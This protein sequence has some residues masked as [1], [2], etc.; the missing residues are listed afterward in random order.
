MEF[1][2]GYAVVSPPFLGR[3]LPPLA[4]GIAAHYIER[5][6]QR[7]DL[8][9]DPFGQGAQVA[10]EALRLERR[11]LVACANP[12]SRLALSLAVRPPAEGE[13]RSALTRLA[14]APKDNSRLETY[15]K[16][17]YRTACA[18]CGAEVSADGF[19]WVDDELAYR[20]YACP[21]CHHIAQREPASEADQVRAKNFPARGLDYHFLL[22][23]VNAADG[24]ERDHAE[25]A[26]VVYPPRTLAAIASVL[27][28]FEALT[29]DR[30]VRR[31]LAGLFVAALDATCVLTQDRPRALTALPRRYV[32][33][34]FWLALE[35]ATGSLA[36]APQPDQTVSLDDLLTGQLLAAVHPS[37][38]AARDLARHLPPGACTLVISALPRPNQ[39]YWTLSALWSAWLWGH[40]AVAALHAGLRRRR[41]D[42]DWHAVALS[43]TFASCGPALGPQGQMIGLMTEA[44]PGFTAAALAAADGAGYMLSGAALRADTAEAQ[45]RWQREEGAPQAGEAPVSLEEIARR[46]AEAALLSRGEPARWPTVHFGAWCALAEQRRLTPLHEE[47]VSS[48]NHRL[49]PVFRDR[50]FFQRLE[51]EPKDDLATGLWFLP[52]SVTPTAIPLADRVEEEVRRCLSSGEALEEQTVMQTVGDTLTGADTPDMNLVTACLHSYGHEVEPGVWQLRPE[53]A[54]AS[55]VQEIDSI[56]AQLRV[57][58]NR[59]AYDVEDTNPQVWTEGGEVVYLFVVT[60][61]AVLSLYRWGSH[62]RARRRFLV[63]P[64]GRAGLAAFKL[65]RDPRLR[66]AMVKGNWMMLKFRHI[67]R[68]VANTQ[69]TRAT[70][71]P[72]FYADPLDE[73]RQMALGDQP[74]PDLGLVD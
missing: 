53:D 54:A 11:V 10:L 70:L 13:L 27:T 14:D 71:E 36:G 15:L 9:F 41:Y 60:T 31:R 19:E 40:E 47:P 52:D 68:M 38:K 72:A 29:P 5:C 69:L 64:G 2:P 20:T 46:G 30:E 56:R 34:N 22:D 58:A 24:P 12:V 35:N 44:E 17:L 45:F 43:R 39:A 23:R 49:E 61:S 66:V 73:A 1:V 62:L 26:L 50:R 67:R 7:G 59:H 4:K 55:R 42:W 21:R 57:L 18:A 37:A 32:E 65:R 48:V 6:S 74:S 3:F 33:T 63:L 28:R 25:E 16:G 51:A 8:V